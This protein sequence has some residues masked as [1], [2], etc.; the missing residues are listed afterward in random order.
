MRFLRGLVLL[1]CVAGVTSVSANEEDIKKAQD[2]LKVFISTDE[3]ISAE[4]NNVA[5]YAVFDTIGKGG[6]GIGGAHGDGVLFDAGGN[7]IGA[8]TMTQVS[9]GLQLGGQTFSELILF[10]TD[11]ALNDFK[12]GNFELS[13]QLSAVAAAAGA[14]AAAPYANGVKV[15]TMTKKG[16]MYEASVGGQKFS[17][18]AY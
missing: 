10:D 16:L 4:L 1:L 9:V 3:S 14:A 11:Q 7:A 15:V 6:I 13:A 12:D 18:E 17:Y 5:G 2:A 8:T